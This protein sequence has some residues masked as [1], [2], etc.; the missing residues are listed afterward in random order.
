MGEDVPGP[1]V[2][3]GGFAN[4]LQRRTQARL[5]TSGNPTHRNMANRQTSGKPLPCVVA[6]LDL[7]GT[8]LSSA[9]YDAEGV[10]FE[11]GVASLGK[12][13]GDAVGALIVREL[14]RL[15]RLVKQRHLCL[16]GVGICVPGIARAKTG[17]VWAPNIPGWDDYPLRDEVRAAVTDAGIP[18]VVDS[19]RAAYILGEVWLGAAR[20]CRNAIFLSVGTGIGA[21]I[22]VDGQVLRGAHDSA[23][24]IGW[25][26]PSQPFH[27]AYVPCGDFEYH[28]SGAGLAKVAE[29]LVSQM[30]D[31]RG[32]LKRRRE[33][34]A[35]DLFAAHAVGDGVA[36]RVLRN[37]VEY[38]GAACANLV[39]L[40]NP[41]KIIFGGGVF[42]PAKQFLDDI[43]LEAKQWAQPV[44]IR[45]VRFEASRLASDAGL[46]GAAYLAWRAVRGGV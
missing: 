4:G 43:K 9:L 32:L 16:A 27:P 22:L 6:A 29:S 13:T 14:R 3:C 11:R 40:F 1:G 39:S 8:K 38:W 15:Q 34:T 7:G 20:G 41:E 44:A 23:G 30:P 35:R 42:G 37:A 33:L 17:R 31:Y 26:A 36:K 5:G 10:A 19:D 25:L 2:L 21:G 12:R 45:E 46:C 28:A 18:V 24:S